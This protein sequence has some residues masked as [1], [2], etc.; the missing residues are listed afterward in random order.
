MCLGM[1]TYGPQTGLAAISQRKVP[2][3]GNEEQHGLAGTR[4]LHGRDMKPNTLAQ[5]LQLCLVAITFHRGTSPSLPPGAAEGQIDCA[6][7]LSE[8]H[9]Q[10]QP[11]SMAVTSQPP[12]CVY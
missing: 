1:M 7:F 11:G 12:A 2:M 5:C 10:V 3:I 6:V 8:Q 9:H 4:R